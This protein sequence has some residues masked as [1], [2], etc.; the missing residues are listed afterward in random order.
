MEKFEIL[1]WEEMV[2]IADIFFKSGMFRDVVNAAQAVV[3]I[4]AG[5]E[6]GIPPF[7]AMSGIYIIQGKAEPGAH[8]IANRI[9]SNPKY[10]Y[11]IKKLDN[12][13]CI[14]EFFENGQLIGESK[15]TLADARNAG[16]K[17]LDKFPRNM[18][19]ARAVSNGYKWYCPDVMIIPAY[20]EDELEADDEL[21]QP[22]PQIIIE[23]QVKPKQ[24]ESSNNQLTQEDM[25]ALL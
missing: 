8:I 5:Q 11:K 16:T 3:K 12:T 24:N 2:N 23:P 15:F 25:E 18:L 1:K 14:L 10:D 21:P 7:A 19:F 13:E 9:K 6:I 4:K 20:S 22:P 17:N